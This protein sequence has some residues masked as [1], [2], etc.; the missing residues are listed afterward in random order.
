MQLRVSNPATI[1]IRFTGEFPRY[2]ALSD[3]KDKLYYFRYLD[4]K[5]PRIKFNIVTPDVYTGN[6][7][8]EVLK[9]TA[10]QTPD[11]YP[12]LPP[13]QR[14]RFKEPEF[15]YNPGLVGTPARIYTDTGIIEHSKEYYSY[16]QPVR[17]FI[18]L[19]ETGHF[20]YSTEEYCDMW[21]LVNYLRM[22]YNRS[23][24]YYTLY[25]IL[26]YSAANIS[27]L[28]FLLTQIDITKDEPTKS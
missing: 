13:A 21:A 7:P 20:F 28:E 4:G 26:K 19:H 18:D 17:L 25:K 2:F 14:N 22:G 23:T 11:R 9:I 24:A 6:Y 15:V 3:S 5:T 16:P 8:F 10:I 12:V 27:R 1:Y